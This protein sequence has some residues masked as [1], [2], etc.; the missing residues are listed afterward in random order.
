MPVDSSTSKRLRRQRLWLRERPQ[1]KAPRRKWFVIGGAVTAIILFALA[2]WIIARPVV[3]NRVLAWATPELAG[4]VEVRSAS[5]G[6][7]SGQTLRG[8]EVRG[9]DDQPLVRISKVEIGRGLLG[10]AFN[11]SNLG[12]VR[13]QS[14]EVTLVLGETES[15]AEKIL[16]GYIAPQEDA[17]DD[18]GGEGSGT[19][20]DLEVVDGRC[21]IIDEPRN[22][23]W[24][25]DKIE[26]RA[27]LPADS[28]TQ[29]RVEAT[30]SLIDGAAPATA[31]IDAT[32]SRPKGAEGL[33][34]QCQ[35]KAAG[36]PVELA[37][38]WI[39]QASP[40]T[41]ASGQVAAELTCDWT[42]GTKRDPATARVD[43]QIVTDNLQ[44]TGP[45]LGK[46]KFTVA[47]I[48]APCRIRQAGT[49]LNVEQL[50]LECDFGK[51]AY[52]GGVDTS[53]GLV[54][55]LTSQAYE[56]TGELDLAKLAQML[57]ETVHVRAGTEIKA[58]DVK[59]RLTSV[60]KEGVPTWNGDVK[61]TN[62]VAE[63]AGREI[64]WAQPLTAV[65]SARQTDRGLYIDQMSCQ[66][67]FL[68]VQAGGQPDEFS[69]S[70]EYNLKQLAQELD[71]FFD[72]G[73]AEL[74]GD[75]WSYLKWQRATDG[76]FETSIETQIRNLV[77]AIPERRAWREE[78]LVA[79]ANVKGTA[80]GL[81]EWTSVDAASL[82]MDSKLDRAEVRLLAPV[83]PVG[84]S[85]AWP[86]DIQARGQIAQW[87]PRLAPIVSFDG[88]DISGQGQL[89]G[90][91]DVSSDTIA[92]VGT[93]LSLSNFHA[94]GNGWYIDE[95]QVG[96][97]IQANVNAKQSQ[98]QVDQLELTSKALAL[99]CRDLRVAA[100]PDAP[101]T[102]SGSLSYAADL[103][104]LMRWQQN[105]T[106]PPGVAWYGQMNGQAQ[107]S[108]TPQ[109]ISANLQ[110]TIDGLAAVREGK[111]LW[112][113]KQLGLAGQ[114]NY[115]INSDRLA[116]D[117]LDIQSQGLAMSTRG[118]IDE[119]GGMRRLDLTGK[120]DYDMAALAA[121]AGSYL[122]TEI[123]LT[124][125]Q[126]RTFALRG[127]LGQ[128]APSQPGLVP[129]GQQP[130]AAPGT[131]LVNLVGDASL[132][133]DS[134]N[135]YGFTLG[136]GDIQARLQQGQ[137]RMD[138]LNI[139]L[140]GGQF[141][142]K[143]VLTLEPGP[144]L[145]QVP[146]SKT[147]DHAQVSPEMC[148]RFLMFIA[149]VMANVATASGQFSIDLEGCRVPLGDANQADIA[150]KFTVHSVEVA[151]GPLVEALN[152]VLQRPSSAK[153][154]QES[155]VPFRMVQGRIYHRDLQL[156]FPDLTI[157]TY[158]SV[159]LDR[160]LAIMAEMPVPPKWIGN[161]P[162][163]AA[164]QNQIV[165][166]PIGGTL[167]HPE[168]DQK[169]L[170]AASA[171]FLQ[172]AATNALKNEL[173]N[174]LDRFLKPR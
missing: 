32:F 41:L 83:T 132:G 48:I 158:G 124:G 152:V 174:Q 39:D 120:L 44:I 127:P 68:R 160:S 92:L 172:G 47:R 128:A 80:Q 79:L 122:G 13:L 112:R 129:A 107:I 6:W 11:S 35:V 147:I 64:T 15:N 66:S 143:P 173:N 156:V 142:A 65:F 166:L 109:A 1:D 73:A 43:G 153:L 136:K 71:Q 168:I 4:T 52:V 131:S 114:I 115:D 14:P 46:D 62:L 56:V 90:R 103:P 106:T 16:A 84:W 70:A 170:A 148:N 36:V 150:G 95:P 81:S 23:H 28:E 98:A 139:P 159:G 40:G 91:M 125:R 123:Q 96:M 19:A 141:N 57:P 20:I 126:S 102:V 33:T 151:A 75:G 51:I 53:K 34:G 25:F 2:P 133:F 110:S 144:M 135:L 97:K 93:E 111:E 118:T 113:E 149:P 138:M 24:R 87:L 162:L 27:T 145:L 10:L 55:S 60:Q 94:W 137:L 18:G 54:A 22:Q 99:N 59:L 9:S 26:A 30:A 78:N 63:N 101:P 161:N 77:V 5:L 167:D 116:L 58:G 37:S 7:F 82:R 86:L 105:P 130:P 29:G 108:R 76:R 38:W 67:S 171:Q 119:L 42:A 157:R 169:A 21:T 17:K 31:Q 100:P 61:T 72:L 154:Q 117:K 163:G 134:G 146:A 140:S 69:V 85:T 165:K 50:G 12:S 155:V 164:L 49:M 45:W 89:H 8:L 3:I 88:W 121:L 74:A 104:T